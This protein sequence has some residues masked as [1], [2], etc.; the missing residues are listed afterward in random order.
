MYFTPIF[1]KDLID[2]TEYFMGVGP[3]Q[4]YNLGLVLGLNQQR[5]KGWMDSPT[6]LDDVITAWLQRED[7][8][9]KK[10]APTWKTLVKALRHQRVALVDVANKIAQDKSIR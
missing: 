7:K 9:D 10:G 6:F 3:L 5:V 8:V 2:V 1:W 4:L